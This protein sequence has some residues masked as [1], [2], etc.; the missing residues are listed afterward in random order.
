MFGLHGGIRLT[1]VVD[2]GVVA[3]LI[4]LG[5]T[6]FRKTRARLA[7]IGLMILGGVDLLAR[8][9]G[10]HVTARIL[11]GFFA[12]FVI[13]VIVVFQ[14]EI[15]RFF[16][17]IAVLWMRR[18]RPSPPPD[19]VE[20]IARS[21]VHMAEKKMGALLVVPG[22][23][24]VERHLEGGIRLDALVSEPLLV[25]L[26]DAHSPGHD[27]AV[28]I[29][30]DR[31]T[32]FGLRLPL[33]SDQPQLRTRGTRHAAALGLSERTDSLTVVVSEERGT[34]SIA[35]D[36]ILRTLAERGDVRA[37]LRGFLS[38]SL[39]PARAAAPAWKRVGARWLET[40]FAVVAAVL[41]W[42]FFSPGS[43][44]IE[45]TRSVPV[46]LTDI[47][48][49]LV[50]DDVNPPEIEVTLSGERRRL[51]PSGAKEVEV[52]LSASS[53]KAGLHTFLVGDAEVR[54]P[55]PIEVADIQPKRVRVT[56]RR[57]E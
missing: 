42:L 24:P 35:K 15:R 8:A 17:Q 16:E 14:D 53:L 52:R 3:F 25:S 57:R 7:L 29:E 44:V 45:I 36:G 51:F 31:V 50:I 21:I 6:W 39:K 18:R 38:E 34:V 56:A 28:L 37:E 23:E 48:A 5:I 4:W 47:P 19:Y 22:E 10:L 43:A 46:V 40:A 32:R 2:I 13:V 49:G 12:A 11:Q 1:D 20:E 41:L 27:G 55:D 26:F 54:R 33:S 30:G 9:L